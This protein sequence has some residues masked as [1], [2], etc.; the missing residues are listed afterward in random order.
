[1]AHPFKVY[2]KPG[3][4]SLGRPRGPDL[5]HQKQMKESNENIFLNNNNENNE[6]DTYTTTQKSSKS[7]SVTRNMSKSARNRYYAQTSRARHRT[8]VEN[9]ENDRNLLLARLDKIE[10]EN[11]RMREELLDLKTASKRIKLDDSSYSYSTSSKSPFITPPS[12]SSKS[13]ESNSFVNTQYALSVLDLFLPKDSINN[14]NQ[15]ISVTNSPWRINLIMPLLFLVGVTGTAG[16]GKPMNWNGNYSKLIQM[17]EILLLKEEECKTKK[18]K[19]YREDMKGCTLM[20]CLRE[21]NRMNC[22]RNLLLSK[23]REMKIYL[24]QFGNLKL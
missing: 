8:Y 9:L 17:M 23:L 22:S 24:Q 10:E 18:K 20:K 11:R 13:S 21:T 15:P 14:K 19:N 7:E 6:K 12:S 16:R 1:M 4:K 3:L 2:K 5:E